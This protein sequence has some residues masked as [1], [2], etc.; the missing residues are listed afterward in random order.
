MYQLTTEAEHQIIKAGASK[1]G[2]MRE[3]CRSYGRE[4]GLTK[5][6][7]VTF[8]TTE[9]FGSSQQFYLT[10]VSEVARKLDCGE[11]EVLY[12]LTEHDL[13]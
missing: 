7:A 12:V 13:M 11:A 4:H 6:A 9:L 10:I 2:E 3:V 5:A 8:G 1:I